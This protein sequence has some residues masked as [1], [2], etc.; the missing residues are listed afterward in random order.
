M[1]MAARLGP[2][3]H[4]EREDWDYSPP[5]PMEVVERRH[6]AV[7]RAFGPEEE[8]HDVRDFQD[9]EEGEDRG[10][11]TDEQKR[12]RN[13]QY[14]RAGQDRR[15]ISENLALM[16]MALDEKGVP[17]IV[18]AAVH[19]GYLETNGLLNRE[20]PRQQ[21][22]PKEE[23]QLTLPD[24]PPID[25][26]NDPMPDPYETEELR[27]WMTR[28]TQRVTANATAQAQR[29]FMTEM[30]QMRQQMGER[31]G[32]VDQRLGGVQDPMLDLVSRNA[33]AVAQQALGE[34]PGMDVL[35]EDEGFAEQYLAALKNSK[36]DPRQWAR[37]ETARTVAGMLAFSNP[38]VY[39]AIL[40]RAQESVTG[41]RGAD[42]EERQIDEER[43]DDFRQERQ[44][45]RPPQTPRNPETG[46]YAPRGNEQY[47]EF[48]ATNS[49]QRTQQR[50]QRDPQV[51]ELAQ[52]LG[53][54]YERTLAGADPTG[55]ALAQHDAE[56]RRRQR[57]RS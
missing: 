36:L 16:G 49:R 52:R 28:H 57:G 50:E 55:V 21:Q 43:E 31:F 17:K 5:E 25:D 22:R 39:D 14:S 13:K 4:A 48:G 32:Q 26:P 19:R 11:E 12:E 23:P 7:R 20:E 41:K 38:Q 37:P 18:N 35:L 9:D 33:L 27:A 15:R 2:A 40:Q 42:D 6:E 44:Q 29:A 10:R 53:W 3:G 34:M 8:D 24:V 30:H 1:T 47:G 56:Q 46:R 54:T 51:E 45:R